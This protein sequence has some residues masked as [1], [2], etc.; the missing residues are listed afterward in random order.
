M[1]KEGSELRGKERDRE[2]SVM[3]QENPK[4]GWRK[5][6]KGLRTI[7]LVLCTHEEEEKGCG[8]AHVL[9]FYLLRDV[10]SEGGEGYVLEGEKD[11]ELSDMLHPRWLSEAGGN[12]Y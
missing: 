3:K 6:E 7:D 8:I 9:L 12:L 10:Q 11:E 4:E 2:L 1:I 5:N